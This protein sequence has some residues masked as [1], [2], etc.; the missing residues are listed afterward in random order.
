MKFK[1]YDSYKASKLGYTEKV[2]K[3]WNDYRID[4][5]SKLVRGN[6]SFK[7][8]ELLDSG[9]YVGLQYGKT[10]QVNEVNETFK[11]YVNDKFYKSN[12]VVNHGDTILISTSET[13]EDL[14]HTCFYNRNDLGLIGG[15]QIL[16]KPNT[17]YIVNKYLFY[18]SKVFSTKLR[19]YA[20]GLK[21]FRINNNNLKNI[22]VSLPQEKTQIE[23]VNYLDIKIQKIDNE[24][25]LFEQK[26]E[27]YKELKKA[28]ISETVL[29]GISKNSKLKPSNIEWIGNIPQHWELKRINEAFQERSVKVSDKDFPPL[30]VTKNGVVPQLENV[31][32]TK[33]NDG[34]KL[35]I[36]GDYV[37][38]SRSDR[39]GSSGIAT[40]D[41]SVS[42]INI[43]LKPK[44]EF[45]AKYLHH[46]FRNY[47]FIE[48]FYRNGKGIAYDLWSTKY[49]LM[50]A[51]SFPVP[52]LEEQIQIANYLDEKTSK[53]DN[54]V[55][56]TEEKIKLLKE[57]RKTLINDVV[58][59]KVKVE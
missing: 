53:I 26:V 48:E 18:Y 28:L 11:F 3:E 22:F 41:G 17:K 46:L 27:K 15:E 8:D 13:L 2:S 36:S 12:Q 58:T 4:W 54:I 52:P 47:Y 33:H 25:V 31:A 10:Y 16:I 45:F 40:Q 37:I 30:S 51:I 38:N 35:V 23:I 57:F 20:T 39:R 32:K 6:S 14:G 21:V 1:R 7:K 49:S 44:R 43:V 56:T 5:I 9:K 34:R 29:S 55:E 24:I 19:K 59:G 42:V 50:R